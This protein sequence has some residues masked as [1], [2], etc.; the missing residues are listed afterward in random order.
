MKIATNTSK[1]IKVLALTLCLLAIVA[2]G[3]LAGCQP[4][5]T[6]PITL[7][8]F[9][10]TDFWKKTAAATD[11]Q[12]ISAQLDSL[13]LSTEATGAIRVQ[14]LTFHGQNEKGRPTLY[15]VSTNTEGELYWHSSE[16]NFSMIT[17]HPLDVFAE[18]DSY[19]LPAIPQG[20][21]GY[22]LRVGY[23]WGGIKY[24]SDNMAI[25]RLCDGELTPLKEISFATNI[26]LATIE[27]YPMYIVSQTTD[28]EGH[29]S[30]HSTASLDEQSTVQ[31]WFLAIDMFRAESVEYAV[32]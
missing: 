17:Q 18:I 31:V 7:D 11:I 4:K 2:S 14:Y 22:N 25:Y 32:S 5:L 24:S 21:D 6:V 19:G 30:K 13:Y 27:V 12:E 29:V 1:L 23:Q 28:E 16:Q 10:L 15:W 9:T 3:V 26:P 8:E 20:D